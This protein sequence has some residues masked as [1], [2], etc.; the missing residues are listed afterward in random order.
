MVYGHEVFGCDIGA[1][2]GGHVHVVCM[3]VVDMHVHVGVHAC[4][5]H[6]HVH[7]AGRHVTRGTGAQVRSQ[8]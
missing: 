5:G 3:H 4:R 8:T 6:V 2:C 1:A 7:V